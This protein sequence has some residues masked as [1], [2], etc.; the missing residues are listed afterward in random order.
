MK[1]LKK[2]RYI[3]IY[4]IYIYIN[5][6]N[7]LIKKYSSNMLQYIT[8]VIHVYKVYNKD[9]VFGN[10]YSEDTLWREKSVST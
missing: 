4:L 10:D 8:M 9:I 2:R 5:T 1:V 3:S 6:S 7:L